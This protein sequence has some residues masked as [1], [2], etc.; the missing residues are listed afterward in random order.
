METKIN[1]QHIRVLL[2]KSAQVGRSEALSFTLCFHH[3]HLSAF[4]FES[5]AQFEI[6][7]GLLCS[8][9]PQDDCGYIFL[10]DHFQKAL[11]RTC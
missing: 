2:V 8:K 9:V 6:C 4:V 11:S 1:L 7:D 5:L 10:E 3:V